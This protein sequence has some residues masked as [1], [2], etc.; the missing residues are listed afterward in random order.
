VEGSASGGTYGA[1]EGNVTL[2][3]ASQ[4]LS[5]SLGAGL[6][7]SDGILAFNN[8]YANDVL[9]GRVA[10]FPGGGF[11]AAAAARQHSDEY[12][13][14]T[15]G[16]G[17]VVDRN[18]WR[19]DRRSAVSFDAQQQLGSR[20]EVAVAIHSMNARPRTDDAS[21]GPSDTTGFYAFSSSASVR[22]RVVDGHVNVTLANNHIA[23]IGYEWQRENQRGQDSSNFDVAAN[24]FVA[25]RTT[26]A[27]YA[28]LVG[29][30][31]SLSYT[32]GGRY[33]DNDVFGSFRTARGGIAWRSGRGLTLRAGAGTAFK[34][35]TFLEQFNTAFTVGNVSLEPERS[36]GIEAGVSQSIARGR[37]QLSAT[38][39]DQR[40][41]DLIQYTFV[42]V[43]SPNYFNVAAASARGLEVEATGR[44][45]DQTQLRAQVT[46]LKTRVDDAG[47]DEGPN[48]NFVEGNRL[49]RRPSVTA[50]LTGRSDIT[51]Q[52]SADA[53]LLHVGS[54]DDRDFSTFPA[55]PLQLESYRRLD[56]GLSYRLS[57]SEP[58]FTV[59]VRAENVLDSDYQEIANFA[60]PGRTIIIGA[61]AVSRR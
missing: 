9:S 4:S 5:I 35:P 21:D 26:K 58:S 20:L 11:R 28:Q 3:I 53:R 43:S 52:L 22:R 55:A 13:Y 16:A 56:L 36:R 32:L 14:P 57:G 33:D 29:E 18:A 34:A 2:G 37:A 45:A 10:I 1:R 46:F 61:R 47:F 59:F 24:A 19:S 25:E 23:T 44:V 48:A 30:K 54:R 49:L 6:R 17:R 51:S 41:R 42:D 50:T 60:S 38:W 12:H 39:F 15:D 40:F 7:R 31:G 27:T 8:D